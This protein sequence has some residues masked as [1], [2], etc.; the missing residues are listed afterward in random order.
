MEEYIEALENEFLENKNES[1]AEKMAKYMK[2]NFEFF[3][4]NSPKRNEIQ[5]QFLQKDF[6]PDKAD[7]N[8]IVKKLWLKPQREFQYF[9][10]SLVF[11]YKQQFSVGDI[12]LF[13]FMILNKSWWDSIDFIAPNLLGCYFKTF[14]E[15]RNTIIEKWLNSE[16]I[17]L[18]RS[19]ILFQ[20][21]YK[22]NMDTSF[23]SKVINRLNNSNEFF[24]NKAIGWV[25][26]EYGKTDSDWVVAFV[27]KTSLSKLSKREALRI[28]L[29]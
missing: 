23:L 20:L 10:Q 4:I 3:G 19:C 13:E 2:N 16:N 6:L 15:K 1:N 28:I 5:K 18:Q 9:A 14:P 7:L 17:W 27:Q 22:E 26:R 8:F 11:K 12:D 24:I 29:K 25:L 21:K